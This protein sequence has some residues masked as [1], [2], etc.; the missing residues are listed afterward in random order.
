MFREQLSNDVKWL[1]ARDCGGY[2]LRLAVSL[3][4]NA[5]EPVRISKINVRMRRFSEVVSSCGLSAFT[6]L[7]LACPCLTHRSLVQR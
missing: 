5:K 4:K 7:C 6:H 3:N 1:V 2:V